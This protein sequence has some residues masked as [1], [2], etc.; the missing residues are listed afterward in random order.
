VHTGLTSDPAAEAS[1][2]LAGL[3]RRPA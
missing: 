1:R 3:V 2:L